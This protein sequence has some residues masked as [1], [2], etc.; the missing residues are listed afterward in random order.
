MPIISQ[1]LCDGC[2][3]VKKETNHWYTLVISENYEARL[4][5][6]AMTPIELCQADV[7]GVQYLCGRRCVSQALDRWMDGLTAVQ[8]GRPGGITKCLSGHPALGR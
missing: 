1:I 6:M 5:P 7:A 3:A 8:D 2:Q 4:R